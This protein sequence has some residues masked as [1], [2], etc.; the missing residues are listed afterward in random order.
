MQIWI[1]QIGGGVWDSAFLTSLMPDAACPWNALWQ[2]SPM[3]LEFSGSKLKASH[4]LLN[5]L[6][7]SLFPF[8]VNDFTVYP[9]VQEQTVAS[10]LFP[11]FPSSAL[12]NW[13]LRH[14]ESI[15]EKVL[16]LSFHFCFY[17]CLLDSDP[18]HLS[19]IC[20]AQ[21][22]LASGCLR[23]YA[24]WVI[25]LKHKFDSDICQFKNFPLLHCLHSKLLNFDK[26]D[27]A[28]FGSW[29]CFRS[30]PHTLRLVPPWQ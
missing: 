15:E 23:I 30:L 18:Y 1:Q 9:P 25:F 26:Q 10:S 29:P 13:S 7:L 2:W 3:C 8:P 22:I 4:S 27:P 28:A 12:P 24:L 6:F 5:W 17:R 20:L 11:Q 19:G 21:G 16:E 14:F